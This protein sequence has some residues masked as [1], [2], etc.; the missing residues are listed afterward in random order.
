MEYADF[1]KA[2]AD[3][4][5]KP[6]P[7]CFTPEEEYQLKKLYD[8]TVVSMYNKGWEDAYRYSAFED[9]DEEY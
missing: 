3:I 6:N 5:G 4:V 2:I 1:R 7:F 9:C 8:Y